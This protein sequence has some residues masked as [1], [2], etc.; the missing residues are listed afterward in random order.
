ML[1]EIAEE[2]EPD[3]AFVRHI[4]VIELRD[5]QGAVAFRVHGVN[6]PEFICEQKFRKDEKGSQK[7]AWNQRQVLP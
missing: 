5:V 1:A 6:E 4:L 7:T 2:A 3:D